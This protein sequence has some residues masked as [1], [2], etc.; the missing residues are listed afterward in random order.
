MP[1]RRT[2]RWTRL[3]S[4]AARM[5]FRSVSLSVAGQRCASSHSFTSRSRRYE[6]RQMAVASQSIRASTPGI[7]AA[8][9][10]PCET[11]TNRSSAPWSSSTGRVDRADVEAPG[12]G[13]REVVVEPAVDAVREP[14]VRARE[15]ELRRTPRQDGD[16]GRAEERLHHGHQARRASRRAV[17]ARSRLEIRPQDRLAVERLAELDVVLF[18][19]SFEPVEAVG[20]VRR[21]RCEAG[22]GDEPLVAERGA[23]E[24]V[25]PAARDRPSSRTARARARPRSPPTSAAQSAHLA[26]G[27][28]R[29]AAVA[30]P[31][32]ADA[33]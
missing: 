11:G 4:A 1:C 23:G 5:P 21:D 25:R 7:R 27:V 20:V 32:V 13:E 15:H 18:A 33:G 17:D 8:S 31:V 22:D 12:P 10:W 16:V 28:P 19:H 24:H 3:L 14:L 6:Q 30:G 2:I 26:A 29:R 9:Q